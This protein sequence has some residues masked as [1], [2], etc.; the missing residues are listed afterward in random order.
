[1]CSNLAWVKRAMKRK[2]NESR[3][4]KKKHVCIV[5]MLFNPMNRTMSRMTPLRFRRLVHRGGWCRCTLN[6]TRKCFRSCSHHSWHCWCW[7]P[8]RSLPRTARV[9]AARL[10]PAQHRQLQ[11]PPLRRRGVPCRRRPIPL[12][13]GGAGG[14]N[15]QRGQG[16]E[17]AGAE[18]SKHGWTRVP[19]W[20]PSCRHW[21]CMR[22]TTQVAR[23][24]DADTHP[25]ECG[26]AR[27]PTC[28]HDRGDGEIAWTSGVGERFLARRNIDRRHR[29][30]QRERLRRRRAGP[31]RGRAPWAGQGTA[32]GERSGVGDERPFGCRT[33]PR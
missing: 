1:M 30:R 23:T 31:S 18:W 25:P 27:H 15:T 20:M 13:R 22:L 32:A 5:P 9:P 4:E 6:L 21:A 3:T 29:G 14:R 28:H 26:R 19:N 16:T 7:W 33:P 11:R 10:S 24:S 8:R 2:Q 17:G 12:R